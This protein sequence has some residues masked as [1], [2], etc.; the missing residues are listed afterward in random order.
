MTVKGNGGRASFV[1]HL[2]R[3]LLFAR[4]FHGMSCYV[5]GSKK[6]YP[7]LPARMEEAATLQG[8]I[9]NGLASADELREYRRIMN[10]F[11]AKFRNGSLSPENARRLGIE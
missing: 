3:P 1:I 10:V 9:A 8:R 6:I 2:A 11:R 5:N 4:G 7:R